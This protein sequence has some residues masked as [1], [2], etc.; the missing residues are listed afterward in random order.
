M[1]VKATIQNTI[2][3]V[4]MIEEEEE[5]RINFSPWDIIALSKS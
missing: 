5:R 4:R 1:V 3:E 2:D